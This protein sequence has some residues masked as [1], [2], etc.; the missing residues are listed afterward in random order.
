METETPWKRKR[1]RTSHDVTITD[2][3]QKNITEDA[4]NFLN[5]VKNTVSPEEYQIFMSLILETKDERTDIVLVV[6]EVIE[7]FRRN[8]ELLSEFNRFLARGYK[9]VPLMMPER[10]E[11]RVDFLQQ[12]QKKNQDGL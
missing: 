10:F 3:E 1:K 9:I 5:K 6:T 8:G 2:A 4:D 11:I 12:Q 7:L